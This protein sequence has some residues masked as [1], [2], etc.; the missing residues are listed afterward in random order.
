MASLGEDRKRKR[1][2]IRNLVGLKKRKEKTWTIKSFEY[3]AE[4]K[5][6]IQE[7]SMPS[8]FG[9]PTDSMD[10]PK[11]EQLYRLEGGFTRPTK[12]SSDKTPTMDEMR[13]SLDEIDGLDKTSSTRVL[14]THSPPQQS[15]HKSSW[16]QKSDSQCELSLGIPRSNSSA[17][18]SPG[19]I[20]S[21]LNTCPTYC[22]SPVPSPLF[23][24]LDRKHSVSSRGTTSGRSQTPNSES[25]N[26]FM[27]SG[28]RSI[29]DC[30]KVTQQSDK[31]G[32]SISRSESTRRRADFLFEVSNPGQDTR[33]WSIR[34]SADWVAKLEPPSMPHGLSHSDSP[35]KS[36]QG[37]TASADKAVKF[38][39][40]PVIQ[41]KA[42]RRK[43]KV[44]ALN[45][46]FNRPLFLD[47][48]LQSMTLVSND[49]PLLELLETD[50]SNEKNTSPMS[51]TS[52]YLSGSS[53]DVSISEISGQRHSYMSSTGD[54][55]AMVAHTL[56][57][58]NQKIV[59][60]VMEE[61]RMMFDAG[62]NQRTRTAGETRNPTEQSQTHVNDSSRP[63][64]WGTNNKRTLNDDDPKLPNDDQPDEERGK[65]PKKAHDFTQRD[66]MK[67]RYACPFFKHCPES[68]KRWPSCAGPGWVSVH[69]VK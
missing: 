42:E 61:L 55:S 26:D 64:S 63:S 12:G 39:S 68:N 59:A 51:E 60:R 17:S 20:F 23:A 6:D 25:V 65:R 50:E 44:S 45:T 10:F 2:L 34:K 5:M 41:T 18:T 52:T 43:V 69:R 37:T 30:R 27:P 46:E 47:T 35:L 31:N 8:L 62:D 15:T 9:R 53:S 4:S 22:T 16:K 32:S 1:N 19:S 36:F 40:P 11:Q 58:I 67:P 66:S 13:Q 49:K 7:H 56:E 29:G 48:Q 57:G 14:H 28:E 54:V 3:I 21:D 33:S 24:R 38:S